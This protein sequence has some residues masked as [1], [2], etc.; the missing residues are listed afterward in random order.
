MIITHAALSIGQPCVS[1][2]TD[3][4]ICTNQVLAGH[5]SAIT[6]IYT[7]CTLILVWKTNTIVRVSGCKSL[8]K[9]T[10]IHACATGDVTQTLRQST[11]EFNLTTQSNTELWI[12]N[13]VVVG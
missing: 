8:K 2:C 9:P 7:I 11:P 1:R 13:R 10:C 6:V 4:H 5:A 3:T 12:D